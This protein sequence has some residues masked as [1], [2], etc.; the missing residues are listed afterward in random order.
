MK[1][2]WERLVSL[3]SE[4]DEL[5]VK[6]LSLDSEPVKLLRRALD[7][8]HERGA[9]FELINHI[10]VEERKQLF[11]Q[12]L[13]LACC[14][15]KYQPEAFLAVCSLPR[16]WT[17]ENIREPATEI[18]KRASEE[19]FGLILHVLYE[20]HPELGAS[21]ARERVD[22]PDEGMRQIARAFLK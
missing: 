2:P 16:R 9:A 17:M 6:L 3:T 14:A 5:R 12:L 19:E 1:E 20:V 13:D 10:G 18:L 22:H 7:V 21:I 11:T 4:L 15:N 8:P